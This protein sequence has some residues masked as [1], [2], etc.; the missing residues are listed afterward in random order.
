MKTRF[1]RI[2]CP[3][4]FDRISIPALELAVGMARQN[5][6]RV[7]LLYIIPKVEAARLSADIEEV[8]TDSLRGVAR[9]WLQGKVPYQIIVR[10]G[11]P[12]SAL[13]KAEAELAVDLVVMS[14]HGRIGKKHTLLGSV[15]EQVVRRS[16]C[17]VLTTRPR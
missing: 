7:Y 8:A 15:T 5:R 3:I 10:T 11:A 16:I 9:K 2:L 4:D 13:L 14:T 6:G 1:R 17:P 12:V